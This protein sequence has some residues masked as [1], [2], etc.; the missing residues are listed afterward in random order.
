LRGEHREL[1]DL[2]ASVADGAPV[3]W[4]AMAVQSRPS[5]RRLVSH[6]R[7][8]DSIANLYRSIPLEDPGLNVP[9]LDGAENFASGPLGGSWTE[10]S[11]VRAA[12]PSQRWG[13]LL[14]LERIGEGTS[15]EVY[16]ARDT[17]LHREVALKLL[18]EE[19]SSREARA[20][21]LD[22]ARR[23]ARIRHQHVVHVY[24]AEQYA[25]RVGLWMEL[26][27]G[28]SLEE[29]IKKRGT[30]GARE[31][32]LIGLDLCSA[33]AAVHAAGLLHRD[34]KA[35]NVMR[36]E[37][38]RIVLMDFGTGEELSGTNRLVGT[39]L[40][41]APEIFRGQNASVQSDLYSLGVLLFY[42]ATAKY[43]VVAESMEQL[44]RAHAHRQRRPLRD[45]RP[46]LPE[47]FVRTVERALDSDPTRRY[48]SAGDMEA[49]LRE[50][51]EVPVVPVAAVGATA[52]AAPRW[53]LGRAGIAASLV[54]GLLLAAGGLQQAGLLPIG[55]STNVSPVPT[56]IASVAVL[57]LRD[58]S[59][60][61]SPSL[62]EALTD[63]FISTVGQIGSIRV[64]SRGTVMQHE[65]AKQSARDFARAL[66]VD[67]FLESSM[68]R[69]TGSG[70]APD[71]I[72]VN[73]R[74]VLAGTDA[75]IWSRSFE[76]QLG[77][78]LALQAE[79]ARAVA[80]GVKAVVTKEEAARLQ[81]TPQT[82]PA[83][84]EAFLAGRYH[85]NHYGLASAAQ[86]LDAFTS[87][88]RIDPSYAPALAGAARA[89]LALGF[90]GRIS[91]ETASKDAL[92]DVQR[93][94]R[95]DSNQPDAHAALADLRFYYDWDW[96]GAEAEYRKAI[97]LNPS[98]T[99]A[100]S[101]YARY[102]AAA[103]RIT[104]AV[105]QA[106]LATDL[107][108]LSP[109][110]AQTHGLILFYA[111]DYGG[112]AVQLRRALELDPTNARAHRVLARVREA[113]GQFDAGIAEMNLAL[114]LA[115]E[116]DSSWDLQVIRLDALA[117]RVD[118]A[119]ARHAAL[120][121]EVKERQIRIDEEQLAFV[122][123]AL[124]EQETAL[125]LLE[126]AVRERQPRLLWLA[127][128]PRVDPIRS[129]PRF[130]AIAK[131]LGRE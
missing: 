101:Q 124:D 117:G 95:L 59:E 90:G 107:D 68:V 21:I 57:P 48:Q 31:A 36:E 12:S 62:A 15:C 79:I 54:A 7:L 104:D 20:R 97:D 86:A 85:L 19:G 42:M 127:V 123:L 129:H 39:P 30:F 114:D 60:S 28:E 102:L 44:A 41:L 23:L 84:E 98:F 3:D 78:I 67:A 34:V 119:R 27:R 120:Q 73:A 93:A 109:E 99:Y 74:L 10:D 43:P 5:D 91:H 87:A 66:G 24:G 25:R 72:R 126:Q 116:A 14:L 52:A 22:E 32:A 110:A 49:A 8:V 56:S 105:A 29:A 51:L 35:Q 128:D 2:A 121:R 47:A 46:D 106:V 55:R 81:Q 131:Q 65:E 125:A 9:G 16:K 26:V 13:R 77:D 40:Y 130:Q 64:T 111:R 4:A 118:E 96:K 18:H 61:R 112:A 83:A 37:R 33:L 80:E 88:T 45:L 75:L 69:V 58:Q 113:E 94:L 82:S 122:H 6:L 53:R 103:D 17:S 108:P 100:R 11:T 1:V 63:Q 38:G 50:S 71:R 92:I 115:K 76:R 70:G 89:R